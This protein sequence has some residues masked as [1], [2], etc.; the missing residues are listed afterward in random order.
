MKRFLFALLA[1]AV[2]TAVAASNLL[3]TADNAVSD[4]FNVRLSYNLDASKWRNQQE[5]INTVTS[6]SGEYDLALGVC[7]YLSTSALAGCSVMPCMALKL[8]G[9]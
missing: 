5:L 9:W 2:L 4:R 7:C 3:Y 8:P 1:A 6:G